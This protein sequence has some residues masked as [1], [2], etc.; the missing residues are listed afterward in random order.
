[1]NIAHDA[2]G[3]ASF[4][5]VKHGEFVTRISLSVNGDHNVS[6]ALSALAVA[7]ILKI[8]VQDAGAGLKD[9]HG[10]N[11]RFEYK[12]EFNGVTVIDDYAHHPGELHALLTMAKALPYRRIVCAFQPHTYTRTKALFE[13]FV[14]ELKLPDVLILAEIY[15]AREQND[16]GISSNDLARRIPGAIYCPT[17]DKV[18]EALRAAAQPGDLIITV[19]AGD[20]YKAGEKLLREN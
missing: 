15:A 19:G 13:E 4:D 6:N 18:T 20:I 1:M 7:D 10:T 11:R 5:F 3:C 14:R 16:I 9:F 17:L 8:S 2:S 12:G